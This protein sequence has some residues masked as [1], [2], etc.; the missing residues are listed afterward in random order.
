MMTLIMV[1]ERSPPSPSL[2]A[3]A[4][5]SSRVGLIV[6]STGPDPDNHLAD[7]QTLRNYEYP[8]IVCT[9]R[10]KYRNIHIYVQHCAYPFYKSGMPQFWKFQK[11]CVKR[12]KKRKVLALYFRSFRKNCT[13][14]LRYKTTTV[15][16]K[17]RGVS[18]ALAFYRSANYT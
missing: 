17:P 7:E 13:R 4:A 5:S 1:I 2:I 14:E 18:D 11:Y 16:S 9:Y 3:A 6:Q 15:R 12:R 8:V 10:R